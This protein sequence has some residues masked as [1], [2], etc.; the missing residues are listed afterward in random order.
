MSRFFDKTAPAAGEGFALFGPVHLVTLAL[1]A[2]FCVV[3]CRAYRACKAAGRRRWRLFVSFFLPAAELLRDALLLQAG[4]F[5]VDYLPLHLCGLALFLCTAHALHP[6]DWLAQ[7]LY[8]LCLPGAVAALLF[9]NWSACGPGSFRFWHGFLFHIAIV[10]YVTM[11]VYAGELRP[12]PRR[13]WKCAVF[14]A[15]AVPPVYLF[16]RYF[17]VNYMFVNWP[18]PGSPLEG[19]AAR[20]GVPG[21]LLPYTLLVCAMVAGMYL[22]WVFRR[23]PT[24]P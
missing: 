17:Q 1:L 12:A 10:L 7:V 2:L 20:W 18:S 6:C 21:Y 19:F 3:C 16:D 9:P 23:Q 22:P 5:G 4:L 24:G 8:G 11:Q 14:L 13:A 15:A